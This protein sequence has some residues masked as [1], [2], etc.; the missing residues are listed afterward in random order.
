MGGQ[1]SCGAG[2][3]SMERDPAAVLGAQFVCCVTSVMDTSVETRG[4]H[5]GDTE[6]KRGYGES[7]A[8]DSV[9]Q[10]HFCIAEKHIAI[11]SQRKSHPAGWMCSRIDREA[12]NC[13]R[14]RPQQH[15]RQLKSNNLL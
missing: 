13:L 12:A 11:D 6:P 10:P 7:S 15:Q 14:R 2:Q 5:N 8:S 1:R 9:C 4:L 3:R